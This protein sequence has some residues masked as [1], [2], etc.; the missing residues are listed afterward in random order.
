MYP[1]R[2][3]K[4]RVCL[5]ALILCAC[6]GPAGPVVAGPAAPDQ[7][8]TPIHP[9]AAPPPAILP[10]AGLP[11][12][13]Q[14]AACRFALPEDVL[15][16]RDIECG[17][18]TVPEDRASPDGRLIRLAA[19]V[20]HPPGGAEH[21]DPVIYLSGG[22]GVAALETLRYHFEAQT[23]AV[24]A[25]GRDLVLFDQRGIGLSRPA[26]DCPAYDEL[27]L[28]LLDF[29]LEGEPVDKADISPLI[30]KS[31]QACRDALS[32]D[33]DLTHYNSAA[34]AADVEDLRR[35]LG[36][37]LINLWGASYG[38]RLGLEVLRRHP[39]HLRSVV[40]EA[41]YP[42][43]VDLFQSI[44]ANFRRALDLLFE[45]SAANA[46]CREKYPHLEAVLFD[47]AARLEEHPA[48]VTLRD[49][50]S[51]AEY[52]AYIDGGVLLAAVFQI[53]YD[54]HFRYLLPELIYDASQDEFTT[55]LNVRAAMILMMQLTSR[56]MLFSVQLS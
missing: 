3:A 15:E 31:L 10:E 9:P 28:D 35:A 46:V 29:E 23:R 18:L 16:G 12:S 53:L 39:G 32:R 19:A 26:L 52:P 6:T 11:G 34:S 56:G 24:F 13:Y 5:L 20:L 42:P 44:P 49:P 27:A 51:G 48:A 40:L 21:P 7:L 45:D 43:D 38:S 30:L 22:P 2:D 4:W 17:Y 33:A 47:T 36:Y 55:L 8:S 25:A 54:S 50:L 14:P 1:L 41:V 37:E